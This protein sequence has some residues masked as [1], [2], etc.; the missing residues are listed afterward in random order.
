M[1]DPRRT[2]PAGRRA[3][4]MH[5]E[6]FAIRATSAS[7][8]GSATAPVERDGR[9][10]ATASAKDGRDDDGG[11]GYIN[12]GYKRLKTARDDK[13][14]ELNQGMNHMGPCKEPPFFM[15][16]SP[17]MIT[18]EDVTMAEAPQADQDQHAAIPNRNIHMRGGGETTAGRTCM[19]LPTLREIRNRQSRPV[20]PARYD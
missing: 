1:S 20:E 11:R 13:K 12:Y 5:P 2:E 15:I 16:S 19:R 6:Y 7:T 18:P 9:N 3:F 17:L 8:E 10:N 4:G 14:P